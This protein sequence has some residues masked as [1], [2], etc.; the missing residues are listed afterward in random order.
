VNLVRITV[1]T[2]TYNRGYIIE[3]LYKSLQRQTFKD[4]E[5]VVV[6]DG[7][8]DDTAERFERI[9]NEK[10]DFSIQYVKTENGGKHRAIN[11]GVKLA[12]GELFYIV[13]SDDYITDDA[14][15]II[16]KVERTIPENEKDRFCGVCGQRGSAKGVAIG[17]TFSGDFF[18]ITILERSRYK[19]EGDKAEVFY[20]HTM[21]QYPF[22]EFA[23]E[24][25]VTECVI[26]DRMAADG[27][28]LRFFNQIVTICEYLPDGL[29]AI[30][31]AKL[32]NNPR[33][34]S[35]YI[36]QSVRY[37]KLAHLEKWTT[38]FQYYNA[39]R[40]KDGILKIARALQIN[41]VAFW[42][43]MFGMKIFYKLYDR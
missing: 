22:P 11:C 23:G 4:F 15:E 36:S 12:Q 27:Y 1:F 16:D 2:P 31:M 19:I 21:R 3:N 32:I 33:G 39:R 35:L 25:F 38:Y 42:L 34:Y 37:G 24:K 9:K 5:W 20:T 43:R 13:D 26:W 10:N 30:G 28:L 18:D 7:S 41:P 29:T 6:D 40:K 17:T 14:L 8:T